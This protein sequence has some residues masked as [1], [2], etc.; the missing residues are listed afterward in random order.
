VNAKRTTALL[1]THRRTLASLSAALLLFNGLLWVSRALEPAGS[2]DDLAGSSSIIS[3][4]AGTG[5]VPGVAISPDGAVPPGVIPGATTPSSAPLPGRSPGKPVI[6]GALPQG[7]TDETIEVVYYWK[8]ERTET[9]P[10]IGGTPAEGQNLDEGLAFRR[11]VEWINK[12]DGDGTTMMGYPINLHG[13]KIVLPPTQPQSPDGVI[14]AGNGSFSYGQAAELIAE[15]IKPFAAISSHGS[16][17]AYVCPRLAKAGIFNLSTYDLGGLGGNLIERTGGYCVGSGLPW[18]RQIDLTIGFL[19]KQMHEPA[20]AL[21]NPGARVYGVIYT[22]YPGLRDVGPAMID[23]LKAAG[24]PVAHVARLPDSLADSQTQAGNIIAQMRDQGVNTL[25]MP[26]AGSPLNI[27]HAAQANQYYPDY[28]VWPC[29]GTD[30]TGMVRLFQPAQWER[31]EGLTCYDREYDGDVTNT[32]KSRRTEWYK[33]YQEVAPGKEP[34]SPAPLVYAGLAQLVAGL[35]GAGPNLTV[36]TFNTGL[37]GIDPFRYDAID[38][39]TKDPRNFL[40]DIGSRDRAIIKDA[41]FVRWETT[42]R[43]S[44]GIQGAYAYPED[45]RYQKRSQF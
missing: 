40:L 12:H 35:S 31:A 18:E 17:S 37:D 28:Y 13:R 3:G 5:Q 11:Y 32:D 16:L 15:E 39:V 9:S 24:I 41:A 26:E 21:S 38:G 29:S 10:Y 2:G 4:E 42:E 44:G 33:A 25:I 20:T 23:K 27:T 7:V 19:R 43:E 14:E 8:G 30:N 36:E 22:V 6:P 45:I 1:E 34:P